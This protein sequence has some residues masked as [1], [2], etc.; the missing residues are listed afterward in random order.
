MLLVTAEKIQATLQSGW[1]TKI[2]TDEMKEKIVEMVAVGSLLSEIVS[3]LSTWNRE[4]KE[5]HV[6]EYLKRYL[7]KLSMCEL[8]ITVRKKTFNVAKVEEQH[9]TLT[10]ID[11][12]ALQCYET[13]VRKEKEMFFEKLL[14]LAHP[15]I[16]QTATRYTK[17]E[18]D[19]QDLISILSQ[20]LWRLLGKWEPDK[21]YG[22]SHFHYLMLR[23]LRNQAYNELQRF[24]K[25]NIPTRECDMAPGT[26][27]FGNISIGA[28][29]ALDDLEVK[30][31]MF[32]LLA[33]VDDDKTREL[34]SLALQDLTIDEI[35]KITNRKSA[36]AIKRRQESVRP[37]II[38]LVYGSCTQF[39][40]DLSNQI[41]DVDSKN[42]MKHYCAGKTVQ[43]IKQI[44]K[45]S[46]QQVR[47]C[48]EK[49]KKH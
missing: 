43:E 20:D 31:L 3:E 32:K 6:K 21:K 42:I 13:S 49:Y 34:L 12:L 33:N 19:R 40:C 27:D 47:N 37:I 46:T 9:D 4:V 24:T 15:Y 25:A 28:R 17:R 18:Q 35:K 1:R 23:Q 29:S 2:L 16:T 39:I 38:D 22:S 8:T 14:E 30:D 44:L 7:A 10:L 48:V 5:S 11:F 41:E 45:L 36:L 26:L